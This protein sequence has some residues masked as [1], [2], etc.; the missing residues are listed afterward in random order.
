MRKG[1]VKVKQAWKDIRELKMSDVWER[2]YD[3]TDAEKPRELEG[4]VEV[5]AGNLRQ[6]LQGY[7][8]FFEDIVADL[9]NCAVSR[10]VNGTKNNFFEIIFKLHRSG[11]LPCGWCGDYLDG[12][13]IAYRGC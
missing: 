5:I 4:I 11:Y 13:I 6:S 1:I 12:G 8:A 2:Y 3:L 7:D 9:N 10:A